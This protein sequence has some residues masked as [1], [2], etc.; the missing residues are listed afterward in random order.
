MFMQPYL[1]CL[2]VE[3]VE[4]SKTLSLMLRER[5]LNRQAIIL[6]NIDL[7]DEAI[8]EQQRKSLGE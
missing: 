8:L 2:I 4:D 5:K 6:Q 7:L 3:G 1:N